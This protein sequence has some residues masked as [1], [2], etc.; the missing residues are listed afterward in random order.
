MD[1]ESSDL[2]K[3]CLNFGVSLI[4]GVNASRSAQIIYKAT[5]KLRVPYLL[6]IAG[7]D[8]NITFQ[9]EAA[10]KEIEEGLRGSECMVSLSEGMAVI[11]KS[12]LSKCHIAR[13]VY[14]IIQSSCL[15]SFYLEQ[16]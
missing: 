15:S 8:A 12:V 4:V 1:V 6:V 9:N 10:L 16:L 5:R 13:E 2:F 11:T 3:F 7:T 14:T